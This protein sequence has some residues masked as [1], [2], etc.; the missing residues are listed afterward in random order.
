MKV[1][2]CAMMSCLHRFVYSEPAD[3]NGRHECAVCGR[4]VKEGEVKK[5]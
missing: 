5:E 4:F 3:R 2:R 1:C